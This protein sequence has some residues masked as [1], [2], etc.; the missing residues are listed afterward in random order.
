MPGRVNFPRS[1][2]K[3]L[4]CELPAKARFQTVQAELAFR[5]HPRRCPHLVGY[6]VLVA[7]ASPEAG[8]DPTP[9]AILLSA[10]RY[11]PAPSRH[12]EA[13]RRTRIKRYPVA[14]AV[15]CGKY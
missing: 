5:R 11:R 2:L 9:G 8:I 14:V 1:T 12:K 10:F 3:V 6:D 13:G 15:I 7:D 4:A